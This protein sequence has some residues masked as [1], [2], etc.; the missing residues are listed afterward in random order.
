MRKWEGRVIESFCFSVHQRGRVLLF[1]GPLA[2]HSASETSKCDV[3]FQMC[4]GA[5]I[6]SSGEKSPRTL[7]VC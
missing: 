3:T 5:G 7:C 1:T 2:V 4:T 6:P